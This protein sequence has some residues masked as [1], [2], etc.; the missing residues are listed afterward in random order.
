MH[1][2]GHAYAKRAFEA[3]GLPPYV[4]TPEQLLPDPEFSTVGASLGTLLCLTSTMRVR[5]LRPRRWLSPTPR[6][7]RA[8]WRSPWRQLI[9]PARTWC[10]PTT[11]M[12]TV[13]LSPSVTLRKRRA[14]AALA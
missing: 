1:G 2:V 8:R 14:I 6:R 12:P 11:L 5:A 10:W 13:W 7:A 3:F 4:P 9:A